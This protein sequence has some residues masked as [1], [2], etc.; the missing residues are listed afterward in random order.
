MGGGR[1]DGDELRR[2]PRLGPRL[3][4]G[5]GPRL[6]LGLVLAF[7]AAIG[8]MSVR[9][10]TPPDD[11]DPSQVTSQLLNEVAPG[12]GWMRGAP[13]APVTVVEFSDLSCPY[14]ADFHADVR[15]QLISEFVEGDR[16]PVRWITLSYVAGLYPNSLLASEAVECAGRQGRHEL[17]L[18]R[19]YADRD[20][21]LRVDAAD[22]GDVLRAHAQA[23]DLDLGSWSACRNSPEVRDRIRAV[24]A[25]AREV[26]VRGT[27]TWVVDGFPV[28]G[29]LPLAYARSFIEMRLERLGL[30][31]TR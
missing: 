10:Q 22:A 15:A 13:N 21:W 18:E 30:S 31:P 7:V 23:L 14:C 29:A 17:Y 28:M 9:A 26:G 4:L 6:G 20:A 3:G 25:L 12:L 5:V 1:R 19:V 24:N 2:R 11:T 8:P 27:P 16:A